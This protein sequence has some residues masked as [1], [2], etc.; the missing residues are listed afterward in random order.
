MTILAER[1]GVGADVWSITSYTL[2]RRDALAA[3]RWSFLHPGKKPRV[4]YVTQ[5]LTDEPW[6]VIAVS[7]YVKMLPDGIA[8]WIPNG[9]Y[10]LGTDG[11]GRSASREALRRFFEVDAEHI[12]LAALQQLARRG[13][14]D[15]KKI[16]EAMTEMKLDPDKADPSYS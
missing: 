7:D 4:P 6:P 8:R 5:Q 11:F 15:R 12:A 13:Q 2:L 1:F 14:F 3:E 9:L 10:P 16:A